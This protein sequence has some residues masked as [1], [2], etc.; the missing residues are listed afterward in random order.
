MEIEN[1]IVVVICFQISI[2]I[3]NI[4]L[5][6]LEREVLRKLQRKLA[7]SSGYARVTCSLMLGVENSLSFVASCLGIDV[8]VYLCGDTDGLKAIEDF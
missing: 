2:C 3:M 8:S 6:T 4:Q 5:S 1:F 7:G